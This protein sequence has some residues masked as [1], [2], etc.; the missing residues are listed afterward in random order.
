MNMTKWVDGQKYKNVPLELQEY[1]SAINPSS[2]LRSLQYVGVIL[3]RKRLDLFLPKNTIP[4][5]V[6]QS[7]IR[8]LIDVL[9]AYQNIDSSLGSGSVVQCNDLFPIVEWLVTDFIQNGLLLNTMKVTKHQYNGKI[10]WNTTIKKVLPTVIQE[11]PILTTFYKT[12]SFVQQDFLTLIQKSVLADI[13]ANYGVLFDFSYN[14]AKPY[15]LTNSSNKDKAVIFL[16]K[17]LR[18][19]NE[20]RKRQLIKQLLAYIASMSGSQEIS[21][22]TTE[23]HVIFEKAMKAYFHH[24]KDLERFVPKAHWHITID[25]HNFSPINNQIPDALVLRAPFVDIYDAKYYNFSV[26]RLSNT[27]P[28]LDWYSVGKQFFYSLSFDYH[29]ASMQR[30]TNN[31]VFPVYPLKDDYQKV[32]TVSISTDGIHDINVIQANTFKLLKTLT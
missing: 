19:V 28:P 8:L 29:G 9:I 6:N 23:F 3:K 13:S 15:D 14:V 12:K 2:G 27:Y 32:G 18:Y 5:S 1:F 17:Q 30:G 26:P 21:I 11:E 10:D 4:D 25:N 31:F 24:D 16:K 22:V 7:D 20:I